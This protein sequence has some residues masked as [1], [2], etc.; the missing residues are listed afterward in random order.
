[1]L[2]LCLDRGY[3]GVDGEAGGMPRGSYQMREDYPACLVE[4]RSAEA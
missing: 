2:H 3:L 4:N 1:M